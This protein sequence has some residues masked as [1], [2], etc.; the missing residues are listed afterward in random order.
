MGVTGKANDDLNDE[1]VLYSSGGLDVKAFVHWIRDWRV[2]SSL[3]AIILAAGFVTPAFFV[4]GIAFSFYVLKNFFLR[5]LFS[6]ANY[7][8]L[9][10]F[11]SR[12]TLG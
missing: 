8:F 7:F 1:L 3:A 12:E 2:L 10:I 11:L 6:W 5:K 9:R 4:A